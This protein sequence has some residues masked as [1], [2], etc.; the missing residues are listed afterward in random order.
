[1]STP[2]PKINPSASTHRPALGWAGLLFSAAIPVH[3]APPEPSLLANTVVTT[4]SFSRAVAYGEGL[5]GLSFQQDAVL[6]HKG[7][8]YV[9]YYNAARQVCVARRKLPA[10]AWQI[11]E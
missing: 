7:W 2:L 1:M 5:N 9:T 4:E 10:G 11:L 8:Q 3:A 6:S